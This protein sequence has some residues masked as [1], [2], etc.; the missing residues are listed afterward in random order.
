MDQLGKVFGRD[1]KLVRIENDFPFLL[2][3]VMYQLDEAVEQFVL[4]FGRLFLLLLPLFLERMGNH[5]EQD[6]QVAGE[7]SILQFELWIVQFAADYPIEADKFITIFT[8]IISF[9]FGTQYERATVRT[10][11]REG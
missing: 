6:L 5:A 8:V 4:S 10:E 7:K 2:A 11:N 1:A 9:Y 3:M